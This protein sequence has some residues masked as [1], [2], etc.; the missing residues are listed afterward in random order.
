MVYWGCKFTVSQSLFSTQNKFCVSLFDYFLEQ[1][2]L[3]YWKYWPVELYKCGSFILGNEAFITLCSASPYFC[4]LFPAY[5]LYMDSSSDISFHIT[6]PPSSRYEQ[7]QGILGDIRGH[8]TKF[9]ELSE[10]CV[11][12]PVLQRKITLF[13]D[14]HENCSEDVAAEAR[15]QYDLKSLVFQR[16][17]ATLHAL[18]SVTVFYYL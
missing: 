1:Q 5:F 7:D 16:S 18:I 17:T 10:R 12:L 15:S 2:L 13:S 4:L 14:D 11:T 9:E 3:P 6:T 8:G